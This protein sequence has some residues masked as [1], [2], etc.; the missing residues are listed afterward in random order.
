[1]IQPNQIKSRERVADHG[2]VFTAEREVN[3]M[4][5]LVKDETER[6]ESRFLEP[7]CGNGNF[8]AEILRRKLAA[9]KKRYGGKGREPDY[10][11]WSVI[12]VMNIYGVELLEDN[13]RECRERLYNI[14][15]AAYVENCGKEA[16]SDCQNAIR[17]IL[18]KNILC[19]DAL[20]MKQSS[21]EPIIFAEW[22]FVSGTRVKRRDFR[23]DELLEGNTP[24]K[25][26][27]F[28]YDGWE[29]DAET[30]AYIPAS[31]RVFPSTDYRKV[32]D[33]DE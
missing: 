7:A 33:H 26:L 16:E 32:Q 2:E 1:M 23:L 28:E 14:W 30:K 13:A 10:E 3:A 24:N 31:L 17:F 8:L 20:T 9:V 18:K 5:D 22:S 12:A 27:L 11:Q 15:H 6:I 19:G 4:L 29:Y 25:N 21:G